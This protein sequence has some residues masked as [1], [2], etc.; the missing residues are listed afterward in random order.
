M[1]EQ[2]KCYAIWIGDEYEGGCVY[3]DTSLESAKAN[4]WDEV[5][6]SRYPEELSALDGE[7]CDIDVSDLDCGI[8]DNLEGV[9][10]GA[11]DWADADCP[12]CGKPGK[13]EISPEFD[14]AM[15]I[16]CE[17]AKL[18][19]LLNEEKLLENCPF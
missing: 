8:L 3:V 2:K 16:D 1:C 13:I 18:E 17:E 4:A 5:L 11:F 15:C 9:K 19:E 7:E 10:R 12:L 14:E 6:Q